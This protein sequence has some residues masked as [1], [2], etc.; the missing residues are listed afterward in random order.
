MDDGENPGRQLSS[1]THTTLS[2]IPGVMGHV[3]KTLAPDLPRASRET[4]G[5]PGASLYLSVFISGGFGQPTS[6]VASKTPFLSSGRI[7]D[8]SV[9]RQTLTL[10]CASRRLKCSEGP[11]WSLTL[12]NRSAAKI[13]LKSLG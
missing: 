11:L 5:K 12:T 2:D 4:K 3:Q 9:P 7:L 10:P 1:D 13:Q 8:P 6:L